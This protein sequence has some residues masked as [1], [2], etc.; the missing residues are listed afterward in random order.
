MYPASSFGFPITKHSWADQVEGHKD[1][2]LKH[3]E[4]LRELGLLS[5]EK[6]WM[7]LLFSIRKWGDK[8]KWS[9]VL[10]GGVPSNDKGHILQQGEVLLSIHRWK[11]QKC[12]SKGSQALE[13]DVQSYG[14]SIFGDAQG[15]A[16]PFWLQSLA[17]AADLTK[18][19]PDILSNLNSPAIQCSTQK[20]K[21]EISAWK[22][23]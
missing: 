17:L 6:R 19:P 21:A 15:L 13:K 5:M 12:H 2:G 23:F 16:Q 1:R 14:I 4:G 3:K 7:Q 8:K 10:A 11:K 18:E 9:Q 20:M 22:S